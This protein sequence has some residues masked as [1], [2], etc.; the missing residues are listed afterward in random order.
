MNGVAIFDSSN[1]QNVKLALYAGHMEEK[2]MQIAAQVSK[3]IR[4]RSNDASKLT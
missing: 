4:P 3:G 2:S 1:N